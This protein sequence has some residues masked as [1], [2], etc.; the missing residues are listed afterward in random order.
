MPQLGKAPSEARAKL[1]DVMKRF[2]GPLV[3]AEVTVGLLFA[4]QSEGGD[5]APVKLHGYP[6]AAVV[7]ITPYRQRVQGIE[8]AVITVDGALW[9]QMPDVERTALLDHELYH[10]ELARD[11]DDQIKSD[12]AGRPKLKMRLHDWQLGG[13]EAIA[14]R[15]RD[16][17]LEVQAFK[18][19]QKTYSQALFAW[20]DDMAGEPEVA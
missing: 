20:G 3:D 19:T 17:A 15:H 11:K 14:R 4:W 13:F 10:L 2:H 9:S 1:D 6:C 7:R 8:D 18:A 5:M 12:D 16:A